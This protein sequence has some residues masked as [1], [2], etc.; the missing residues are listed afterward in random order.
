MTP[1]PYIDDHSLGGDKM[2]G[3]KNMRRAA[4]RHVSACV[5]IVRTHLKIHLGGEIRQEN[6]GARAPGVLAKT[7]IRTSRPRSAAWQRIRMEASTQLAY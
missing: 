5:R 4:R 7:G 1:H 2:Y 3:I 6:T